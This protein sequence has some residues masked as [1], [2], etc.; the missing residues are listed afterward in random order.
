M[1]TKPSYINRVLADWRPI[2]IWWLGVAYITLLANLL[3]TVA[4][5][6]EGDLFFLF[7]GTM[8]VL[9]FAILALDLVYKA[10]AREA[11][12]AAAA[13]EEEAIRRGEG[14]GSQD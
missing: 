11:N 2:N 5:L 8:T 1:N 4:S 10:R 12:A 9:I 6:I 7:S 14:W 13:A 3:V